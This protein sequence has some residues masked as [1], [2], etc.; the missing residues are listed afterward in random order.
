MFPVSYENTLVGIVGIILS[1][2][3]YGVRFVF[4]SMGDVV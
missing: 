1:I 4:W 2:Y 3:F